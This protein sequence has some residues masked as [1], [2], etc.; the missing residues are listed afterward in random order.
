VDHHLRPAV[1]L[2]G[3][4][5]PGAGLQAPL[6]EHQAALAQVLAADLRQASP[7]QDVVPFG[8]ALLHAV[9]VGPVGVG[10][11]GEAGE[12]HVLLG[13]ADLRILAQPADELN[14]VHH[15]ISPFC[16]MRMRSPR[17]DQS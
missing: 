1:A 10:G 7:G 13:G 11:Q 12:G 8:A 3:L 14:L 15:V 4:V 16:V 6:H 5:L 17:V 2:A 9:A